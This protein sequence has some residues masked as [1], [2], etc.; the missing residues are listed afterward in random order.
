MQMRTP[1]Q[2]LLLQGC[3]SE[4]Y[5]VWPRHKLALVIHQLHGI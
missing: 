3:A 1:H 4:L 2:F 5:R